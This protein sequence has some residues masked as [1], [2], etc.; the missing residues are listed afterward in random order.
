MTNATLERQALPFDLIPDWIPFVGKL[1]DMA[2]GVLA[3]MGLT[4][5]W[6]GWTYGTG[7]KPPEVGNIMERGGMRYDRTN[8]L[9]CTRQPSFPILR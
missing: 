6:V 5:M 8:H 9:A 2:A 7:P 3:G 1:D 4:M